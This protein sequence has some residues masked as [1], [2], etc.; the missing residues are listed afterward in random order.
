MK[1]GYKLNSWHPAQ[2]DAL[3]TRPQKRV[4]KG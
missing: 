4:P 2:K 3:P 1:N